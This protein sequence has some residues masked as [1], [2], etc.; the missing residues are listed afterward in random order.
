[1]CKILMIA[2]LTESKQNAA[3]RFLMAAMPGMVE[4]DKDGVG[5]VASHLETGELFGERWMSPKAAFRRR[6]PLTARDVA[7]R[8]HLRLAVNIEESYNSFG[9]RGAFSSVMLHARFATCGVSLKNVHPFVRE[10]TALI[11]NGVITN[12]DDFRRI[13]STCDSEAILDGYLSMGVD[14]HIDS[15]SDLANA[16]EG[17]YACGV[18]GRD[19]DGVRIMDIFKSDT[20]SLYVSWVKSLETWVYCTRAEIIRDAAKKARTSC[21]TPREIQTGWIIRLNAETGENMGTCQFTPKPRFAMQNAI[22]LGNWRTH[23]A[24]EPS[25]SI[26]KAY[27]VRELKGK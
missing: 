3:N 11:H 26:T 23:V 1:M 6:E 14:T 12:P 24:D 9:N 13:L 5:Y 17:Y 21:S 7:L 25:V 2:G 22:A 18:L 10:D 8:E 19:R 16:L 20:A 27:D 4:N 15:V